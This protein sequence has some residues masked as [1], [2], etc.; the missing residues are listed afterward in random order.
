MRA[1]LLE[2]FYEWSKVPYQRWFK[3]ESPWD[4]SIQQLLEHPEESLGFHLGTFLLQHDFTP[5]PKLENHDVFHVLTRI[6]IT[7]PEEI[8]MQF[9]LLGNGKRS[10][11]LFMVIFVG[12]ILYPDKYALFIKAYKK[13]KQALTFHQLDFKKL[14]ITPIQG[15]RT[16]FLI[17]TL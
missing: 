7:V 10:T 9:Y 16:T 3:N 11:Y 14:L 17:A 4:I 1:L 8:A 6:G 12:T 2:T 15:I 13:G 5:Q